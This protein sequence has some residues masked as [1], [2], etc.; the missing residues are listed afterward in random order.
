[1]AGREGDVRGERGSGKKRGSRRVGKREGAGEW[2][3]EGAGEWDGEREQESGK[4][5]VMW[6]GKRGRRRVGQIEMC[7]GIFL[8]L[9]S[10]LRCF[11]CTLTMVKV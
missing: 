9:G 4:E 3:R 1:M 6:V 7:R 11:L 10:P 5:R 2:E 8:S